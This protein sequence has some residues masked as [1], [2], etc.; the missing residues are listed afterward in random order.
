MARYPSPSRPPKRQRVTL[1]DIAAAAGVSRGTVSLVLRKS[2]LVRSATR[3]RVEA[4]LQELGYVYDRGAASL[5]SGRTSTVGVVIC[6]ITNPFY[7]DFASQVDLALEHA[8]WSSIIAN[9]GESPER[10][11]RILTRMREHG[12][13]GVILVPTADTAEETIRALIRSG[14]PFLQATRHVLGARTDFVGQDH[15]NGVRLGVDHLVALGHRHIAFVGGGERHSASAERQAGYRA[16]MIAHGLAEREQ[17]VVPCVVDPVDASRA[18]LEVLA[19]RPRPTAAVCF[20]D[21]VA[22]GVVGTLIDQGIRPGRDFAVVGFDD[23]RD[24]AFLRPALTTVSI[25]PQ[26]VAE[27]AV[28]LILRRI[29]AP[30]EGPERTIISPRLVVRESCG[31]PH[32]TAPSRESAG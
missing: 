17:L 20:N 1:V 2:P 22:Y 24:I 12:V 28:D 15:F 13:E 19:H 16:A 18:I 7:A 32:P 5:R 23:R 25:K 9:S 21:H 8:G 30:D 26:R 11:D 27:A 3:E 14:L 4:A 10:Q 6:N 31:A 29:A